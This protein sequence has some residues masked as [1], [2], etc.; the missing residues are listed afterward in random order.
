ML[1]IVQKTTLND[2]VALSCGIQ[3]GDKDG[4]WSDGVAVS[5]SRRVDTG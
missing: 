3:Q 5:I 4:S 1:E 2:R